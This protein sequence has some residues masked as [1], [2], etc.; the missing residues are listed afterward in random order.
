MTD[1]DEML[2]VLIQL[3]GRGAFP[4]EELRKIVATSEKYRTAYNL[5]DGTQTQSQVAKAAKV[6]PGNFSRTV[7]RW[8]DEGVLF[9][10]GEDKDARLLHLYPLPSESK[11]GQPA[12][13]AATKDAK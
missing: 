11:A 8:R 4:E 3:M 12:K 10:L 5:C 1:T 7:G 6:D 9:K 2:R 13:E